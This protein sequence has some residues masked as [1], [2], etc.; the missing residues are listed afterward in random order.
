MN[1]RK[2]KTH[3][4]TTCRVEVARVVFL[5]SGKR[6]VMNKKWTCVGTG[7]VETGWNGTGRKPSP[8]KMTGPETTFHIALFPAIFSFVNSRRFWEIYCTG[9]VS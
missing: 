9:G 6:Q 5:L 2:Q 7:R 3:G 1:T 8:L 4:S